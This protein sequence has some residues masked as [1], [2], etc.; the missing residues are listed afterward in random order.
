MLESFH[1]NSINMCDMWTF[2]RSLREWTE[3]A[4]IKAAHIEA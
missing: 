3:K 1:V 4:V 2:Y